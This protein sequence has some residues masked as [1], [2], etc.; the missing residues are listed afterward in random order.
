MQGDGSIVVLL[1]VFL[2]SLL[3]TTVTKSALCSSSVAQQNP[4]ET[5][6]SRSTSQNPPREG[7]DPTPKSDEPEKP[8]VEK[9]K[10]KK[11]SR[12][13]IVIAPL[14]ISSPAIG[15]G[16][17]PVAGYIF[18]L[19]TKDAVSPPSVVGGAGLITNN[20]SAGFAL[21]TDLY[22][23]QDTYRVT[24]G[25]ARGN[26]NY[27][28]YGTGI[29]SG[30]RLPLNQ[31]GYA[32]SIEFLRRI[33]WKFFLGPTFFYGQSTVTINP[34]ENSQVPI[35]PDLGL[36]TRLTSL[37]ALLKRDTSLNRFYPKGGTFF[38]F[39]VS[40]FSQALGSK[41]SFQSYR[42]TFNKYW[43]FGEKQVLAYNGYA[44][45]TGGAPP[46]Y[47]NCIYGTNDELRGYTAGR[48]FTSHMLATQLEYR[49]VL[50][51]R[52]GVVGFGGIGE[53]IPGNNQRYGTQHFLPA[54]GGGLRFM[55]SRK[56]HVNLR[57]DVAR[58]KD[59]HTFSLGVGE[60]F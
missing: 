14:P 20:G 17:V 27:D 42:T 9:E 35:P 55:L 5:P 59:G 15:S 29:A 58:G 28:I 47:G 56:Y 8:G 7:N 32:L 36:H 1:R 16:F 6:S 50:P 10:K 31:T 11:Q 25:F 24:T 48:Y 37:G 41:Y 46:F 45:A 40:F 2:V 4:V 3:L 39:N 38:S 30:Q 54:G 18:P 13:S 23:K 43:G 33:G 60:A 19:S 44:C 12:G 57:A 52:F 21:G 51:W 22:I 34:D 26:V 53:T 49:L